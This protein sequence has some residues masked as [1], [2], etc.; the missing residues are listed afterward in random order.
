MKNI[1]TFKI[2][3]EHYFELLTFATM[4]L[5]RISISPL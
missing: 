4:K 1:I 5:L 2:E 3:T